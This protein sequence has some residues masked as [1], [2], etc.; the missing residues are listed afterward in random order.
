MFIPDGLQAGV[1]NI[2]TGL[3]IKSSVY[4]LHNTFYVYINKTRF[5]TLGH[6]QASSLLLFNDVTR[7]VDT[8]L[9]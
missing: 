9:L 4:L 1:G 3:Y 5:R 7:T 8:P 6:F 2:L